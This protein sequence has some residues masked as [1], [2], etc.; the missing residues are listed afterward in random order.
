MRNLFASLAALLLL[1]TT[2]LVQAQWVQTSTSDD[3]TSYVST[4]PIIYQGHI[5]RTH[6]LIDL[7]QP[8]VLVDPT[9][10]TER[11]SK[12]FVSE[13]EFECFNRAA[14]ITSAKAYSEQMGQGEVTVNS[15]DDTIN[16]LSAYWQDVREWA[17]S[18]EYAHT[19]KSIPI[20]FFNHQPE[21]IW[22]EVEESERRAETPVIEQTIYLDLNSK[23]R[24]NDVVKIAQLINLNETLLTNDKT[25]WMSAI[26][27]LE[28]ECK[29][30]AIRDMKISI[31]P[32]RMAS[33]KALISGVGSK[34]W[35]AVEKDSIKEEIFNIA[36]EN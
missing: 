7:K 16:P 28:V 31:H 32:D 10:L 34:E 26:L 9:D 15:A 35:I 5:A 1:T 29:E 11:P 6:V 8:E 22:L 27:K 30:R 3:A 17:M 21:R 12:S 14:R 36:C 19:C 20:L 25:T 18:K 2:P 24:K 4:K 23:I 13:V 33:Q